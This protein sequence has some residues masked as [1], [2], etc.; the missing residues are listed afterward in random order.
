MGAFIV[1][2]QLRSDS[3]PAVQSAMSKLVTTS[4]YVSPPKNGWIT[5]Y[6]AASDSQDDALIRRIGEGLSRAAKTDVF[7]FMVHDSDI[8]S[9]WLYQCGRLVDQF[10]SAPD[11][12]GDVSEEIREAG[13]GNTDVLIPLCV[14]G[15]TREQIETVIHPEEGFPAFAENILVSLADLLGVDERRIS[16]GFEYFEQDGESILDDASEFKRVG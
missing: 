11:Y 4:A 10:N 7:C 16:L 13:R 6:D 12:F 14:P 1:N 8:A 15:T 9:Y 3:L 5:V 2:F